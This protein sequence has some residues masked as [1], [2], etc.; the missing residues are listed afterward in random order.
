MDH[1]VIGEQSDTDQVTPAD[2]NHACE[3]THPATFGVV[4]GIKWVAAP[5]QSADLD[6]YPNR[7]VGGE[8]VD[9]APADLDIAGEDLQSVPEKEIGG[10]PFAERSN[11]DP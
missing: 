2:P 6:D 1:V 3:T 4:N 8:D 9:F 11:G 10:E 7:A 5:G